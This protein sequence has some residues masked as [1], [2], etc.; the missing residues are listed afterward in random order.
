MSDEVD[1]S[2][3]LNDLLDSLEKDIIEPNRIAK[4]VRFFARACENL[5]GLEGVIVSAAALTNGKPKAVRRKYARKPRATAALLPPATDTPANSQTEE[6]EAPEHDWSVER[7]ASLGRLNALPP[8]KTEGAAEEK[9]ARRKGGWPPG[10]PRGPRK[11]KAQQEEPV[12][13][14]ASTTPAEESEETRDGTITDD[15][16]E[17]L[18]REEAAEADTTTGE[19]KA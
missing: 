14:A 6:A 2:M 5:P 19:A 13:P 4:T 8:A 12:A 10:K 9:P 3:D 7:R 16:F 15:E 11:P 17:E 1:L 18:Q